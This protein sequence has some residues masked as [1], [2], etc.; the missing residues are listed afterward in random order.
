MYQQEEECD[1]DTRDA[2]SLIKQ[3]KEYEAE[4]NCKVGFLQVLDENTQRKG[5]NLQI[6][7]GA[8]IDKSNTDVSNKRK[9]GKSYDEKVKDVFDA[10]NMTHEQWDQIVRETRGQSGSFVWSRAR[11]SGLNI[12]G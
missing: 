6:P 11:E 2:A 7:V 1:S 3:L 4:R 8:I 9:S 12:N 5:I 10:L